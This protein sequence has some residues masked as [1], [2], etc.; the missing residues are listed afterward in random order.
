MI[1]LDFANCFMLA[2][3]E[4]YRNKMAMILIYGYDKPKF[5]IANVSESR[6]LK[7]LLQKFAL[8]DTKRAQNPGISDSA[9]GL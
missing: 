5:F 7:V 8:P 4:Y 3:G 6:I 2:D 1:L 9:N